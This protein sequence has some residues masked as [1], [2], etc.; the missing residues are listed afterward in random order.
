M[1][2]FGPDGLLYIGLGDGGAAFDPDNRAQNPQDL[3]GKILR[4]DVDHPASEAQPYSSPPTNPFAGPHPGRDEIY[5]LGFRN[6]WRFSFDRATGQLLVGDVGQNQVEEIDVVVPGGNY[7]WRAFEGTRCTGISPG[8]CLAPGFIPP[9]AEYGHTEG[10]CSITGGYV[11]RAGGSSLPH[12][13]YLFGDYCSGEIFVLL[14]GTVTTLAKTSLAISSFGSDEDGEIYVVDH[15]G[16][17]YWVTAPTFLKLSVNQK[18]FRPADTLVVS[19]TL[20]TRDAQV[21]DVFFGVIPPPEAGP[22]FGCPARDAVVLLVD[23]FARAMVACFSTFP[24]SFEPV[25]RSL[26]LAGGL[27]LTGVPDLFRATWPPGLPAG[28]YTFFLA[29]TTP[30]AFTDGLVGPEELVALAVDSVSFGP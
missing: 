3:L 28:A 5:A 22:A 8:D 24:E 16:A 26:P 7:G 10:R 20:A 15:G 1:L 21:V 29:I 23:G 25:A 14:D 4:I 12:G 13:G 19:A 27:P 2:D 9:I 18:A 30:G 6:P 11:Y 17:V